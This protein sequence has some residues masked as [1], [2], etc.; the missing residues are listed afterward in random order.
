ML[1]LVS[2]VS[3]FLPVCLHT[4]P[5]YWQGKR[6]CRNQTQTS[7]VLLAGEGRSSVGCSTTILLKQQQN[8]MGDLDLLHTTRWPRAWRWFRGPLATAPQRSDSEA[9]QTLRLRKQNRL[10]IS[11]G[12]RAS[13]DSPAAAFNTSAL[14]SDCAHLSSQI[15]Q[16][17]M[18]P[19]T[20]GVG[21]LVATAFF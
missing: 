14:G 13:V 17:S 3:A 20:E 6:T 18:R 8:S 19:R 10:E 5:R 16:L 7:G 2:V 15:F 11:H 1:L 4:F 12:L 21:G 9:T